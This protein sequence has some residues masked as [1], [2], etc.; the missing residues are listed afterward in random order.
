MKRP[1]QAISTIL[2]LTIRFSVFAQTNKR[3][4]IDTSIY[5]YQTV[6][7]QSKKYNGFL[8]PNGFQLLGSK[9][10]TYLKHAGDYFTWEFKDFNRDGYKDIY[11]DKGSNI[12]ERFDLLLYVA[13]TKSFRQIKDFEK[14]PAPEKIDGA[15]YYYSYHK[16]GCADMNWDSDLF[17]IKDYKAIRLANISGRECENSGIKDGL[18]INKLRGEKK[19]L[20]KTLA[21]D[22]VHTYKEDKWRFIKAYWTKNYKLFL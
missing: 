10:E 21:I 17:Y 2:L 13:A 8:T 1:L 16:S 19:I 12:P 6:T 7:I 5:S 9:N 20:L 22:T 15:K 18:Y 11:L 14:F 4:E 3:T